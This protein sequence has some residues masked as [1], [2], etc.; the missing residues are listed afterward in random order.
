MTVNRDVLIWYCISVT[1]HQ[2]CFLWHFESAEAEALQRAGSLQQ[3]IKRLEVYSSIYSYTDRLS[4]SSFSLSIGL[5]QLLLG[6]FCWTYNDI[7]H[8]CQRC[9]LI[10]PVFW[11]L[12]STDDVCLCVRSSKD[13]HLDWEGVKQK[14]A[15]LWMTAVWSSLMTLNTNLKCD[16]WK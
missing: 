8:C 16:Q 2:I 12:C 4:V 7:I 6:S 9:H 10:S 14:L 3:R 5:V 11:Q 1:T 15:Q 13:D